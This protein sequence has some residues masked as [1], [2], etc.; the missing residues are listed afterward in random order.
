VKCGLACG[1]CR[2]GTI[3]PGAGKRVFVE[4]SIREEGKVGFSRD[5][6]EKSGG[7]D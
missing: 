1:K 7:V 6:K 5:G 4:V 2:G 3:S